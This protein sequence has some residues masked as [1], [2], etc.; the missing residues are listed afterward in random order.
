[1]TPKTNAA[2]P[3]PPRER[4]IA[5]AA[6]LFQKHGIRGIG[7]DAIAEA[8]GTN[9]MTLYRHF[10]SKDELI[11]EWARGI[12][13]QKEAEWEELGA[14]HPNDPQGHLIEWSRRVASKLADMEKRG[15][16][17]ANA[18]AELPE[19]DHPARRVI[20]AHKTRERKRVQRLCTE[21]GFQDPE[22]AA[23][24]FYLLLEGAFACVQCTG[25][26]RI[27]EDL[28]RLVDLMVENS[29]DPASRLTR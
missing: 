15:S 21:A 3:A 7:V 23:N 6:E 20:Q 13:A 8:A 14:R 5:A 24:L 26:K 27:G 25:M 9:K 29:R 2:P 10:A 1:M 12:V 18:L 19:A 28:V 16:M 22:L 17:L 11:A 4:I